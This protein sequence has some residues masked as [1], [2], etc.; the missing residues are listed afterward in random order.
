MGSIPIRHP[1]EKSSNG[2]TTPFE[3]VYLGSSPSFSASWVSLMVRCRSPKPCDGGSNPS[4]FAC[5][6][7]SVEQSSRLRTY[8]SGVRIS[9]RTLDKFFGV[10][11]YIK[12]IEVKSLLHP[13]EMYH[14]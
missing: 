7:S 11:Y 3:G 4:P 14:T 10:C 13:Y 5:P 9:Q 8:V 12:V 2:R 1:I 6:F